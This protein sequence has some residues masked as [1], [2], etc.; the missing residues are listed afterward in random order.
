MRAQATQGRTRWQQPAIAAMEA[1][2]AEA[3]TLLKALA[4]ER[5]LLILCQLAERGEAS[6]GTLAEALAGT[7]ALSQSALSQHLALLRGE[8]L[9]A[10]RRDGTMIHYRI[11][12]PRV[13][14]LLATLQELFCPP[15]D[16]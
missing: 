13:A 5:R 2:A 11:A 10:T 4:N 12:D 8:G 16:A 6:V 3:A 7:A 15:T 14:S 1:K 9:L